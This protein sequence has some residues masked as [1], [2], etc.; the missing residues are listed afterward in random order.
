MTPPR[1]RGRSRSRRWMLRALVVGAAGTGIGGVLSGANA[2][3]SGSVP[4]QS[5][6]NVAPDDSAIIGLSI[7]DTVQRKKQVRLADITN[8]G[9]DTYTLEISL[10]NPTQGTVYGPNGSGDTVT[11]TLDPGDTGT[12]DINTDEKKGTAIPFTISR[13]DP[14]FSFTI[15]RQT[16][17]KGG[18]EGPV[19]LELSG[20]VGSPGKS[21]KFNFTLKNTG[22]VDVKLRK[23]GI[24][25]TSTGADY[26][27]DGGSLLNATTGTEYVT[28][29]IP[30]DNTTDDSTLKEMTPKP[31]LDYQNDGDENPKSIDFTFDKFRSDDGPGEGNGNG[32]SP[33]NMQGEDVKIELEVENLQ[34]GTTTT[35]TVNL[36]S[37]SC[38]F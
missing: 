2:F 12:V 26:V 4:R 36:C 10:D 37:D 6:V 19:T 3:T 33:I 8:N 25:E 9:S 32:N 30:V 22:D 34:D 31:V 23:I 20:S 14:E 15:N 16:T 38:G 18:F 17:V 11:L 27:D 5:K 1:R 35:G 28:D 29:Q 24:V 21:G 7:P 13:S